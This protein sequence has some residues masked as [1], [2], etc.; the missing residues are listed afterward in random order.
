MPDME[1]PKK[2][3]VDGM[4]IL[5]STSDDFLRAWLEVMH[6]IHRMTS[7][8][9][10]YAAILLKKRYKI[11]EEVSDQSMIDKILFDEETKEIIRKE[12][13]VSQSHAKAILYSMKKKGVIDKKRVNPQYLPVWERGKPF[14]WVFVFKNEDK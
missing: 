2:R 13:K 12:A 7:K 6:P 11:A 8:E 10:D 3:T 9:M 4:T 14:R 1:E 5:P